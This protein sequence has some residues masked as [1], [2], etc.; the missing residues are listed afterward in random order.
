[1]DNI[2][3]GEKGYGGGANCNH[4][5]VIPSRKK[6]KVVVGLLPSTL[7][8]TLLLYVKRRLRTENTTAFTWK[9]KEL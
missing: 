4:S 6:K 7:K 9:F 8:D 3:A 5:K 1:M 2:F